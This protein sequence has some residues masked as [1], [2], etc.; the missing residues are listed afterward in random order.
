M[1]KSKLYSGVANKIT[2]AFKICYALSQGI[3]SC[4]PEHDSAGNKKITG[5]KKKKVESVRGSGYRIN[6]YALENPQALS[7]SHPPSSVVFCCTKSLAYSLVV[8]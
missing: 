4:K 3:V 7:L 1:K 2:T 5:V 8:F 6:R